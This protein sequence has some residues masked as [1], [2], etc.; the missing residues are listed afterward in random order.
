MSLFQKSPLQFVYSLKIWEF[1]LMKNRHIQHQDKSSKV[2][3]LL[4]K[5]VLFVDSP[6]QN[7]ST[8]ELPMI[9]ANGCNEFNLNSKYYNSFGY[10]HNKFL[11]DNQNLRLKMVN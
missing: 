5:L 1:E 8:L 9:S 7:R 6:Q 3:Q 4:S 2:L 11:K 10:Q